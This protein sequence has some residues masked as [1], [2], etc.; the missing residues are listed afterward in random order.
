MFLQINW[1]AGVY[2]NQFV[3]FV[4]LL[5]RFF[6]VLYSVNMEQNYPDCNQ[7]VLSKHWK[8]DLWLVSVPTPHKGVIAKCPK[9]KQSWPP[10]VHKFWGGGV[11]ITKYP[12]LKQSRPSRTSSRGKLMIAKCP[13]LKQ[14][15]PQRISSGGGGLMIA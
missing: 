9:L 2:F 3:L 10:S 11:M 8:W 5:M 15:P 4:N 1:E 6:T 14:P 7:D 12:K 13:K